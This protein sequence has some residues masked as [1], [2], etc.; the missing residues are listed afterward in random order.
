MSQLLHSELD[1]HEARL[2][3]VQEKL[4]A[5]D[6]MYHTADNTALSKDVNVLKKK[7]AAATHKAAK[8]CRV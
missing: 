2:E 4:S 8:V 6:D 5:L 7:Y 3:D 1:A